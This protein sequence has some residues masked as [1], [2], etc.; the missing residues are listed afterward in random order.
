VAEQEAQRGDLA[1]GTLVGGRF[2][3][4]RLIGRGGMGDVYAARHVTT[5]KVVA[6]KVLRSSGTVWRFTREARAAT[7]MKHPH[8][9]EVF[10]LFEEADGTPVMVMELL[11]GETFGS[12]RERTGALT[13]EETA[14]LLVP[15]LEAVRTAHAKG[16][17]HRDLKP[18]NIFLAETAEGARVP[19]ILDF[20]LAKMLD[21]AKLGSDTYG[22]ETHTAAVLGTPYYMSFEQAM[23]E[24]IDGR[25]DIWSIGVIVFEALAG[26]R[27]IEFDRIGQM[28]ALFFQGTVPAIRDLVPDLPA[29]AAA[30][31]DRCLAKKKEDRLS[32]L[33][34]LIEV[35][36]KYA[37]ASVAGAQAGGRVVG[38]P[39][40]VSPLTPQP[41]THSIARTR[42]RRPRMAV[43]AV[44]MVVAGAAAA[45]A[46]LL[47]RHADVRSD[48][49][50]LQTSGP[51]APAA[52]ETDGV[53]N[54]APVSPVA[55]TL[56]AASGVDTTSADATAGGPGA[57]TQSSQHSAG[58]SSAARRRADPPVAAADA[59]AAPVERRG[60]AV[61][62]PYG[63]DAR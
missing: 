56:V 26:R 57:G 5:G 36:S 18:D 47:P 11:Q 10:D 7:A 60:I 16:I 1:S 39:V 59:G 2:R 27:P 15:V 53:R 58:A 63:P 62:D 29:D 41:T 17:V 46:T 49:A 6:L 51:G 20:G 61:A 4:E 44:A 55:S 33:T 19:K 37:D 25:T 35:L 8:V 24:E 43:V 14:K 21:P 54:A 30:A 45:G 28:Y 23:S 32:D 52:A 13:L 12:Y 38:E 50:S 31:I 9:V 34:P 3:V 22:Q 48:P 40:A 42:L